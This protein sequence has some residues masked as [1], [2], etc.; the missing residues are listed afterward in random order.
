MEDK[1][2]LF[3]VI[4]RRIRIGLFHSEIKCKREN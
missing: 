3:T 4:R 2:D 1:W